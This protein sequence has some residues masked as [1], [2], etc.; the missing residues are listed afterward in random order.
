[1]S[2][3]WLHTVL[4]NTDDGGALGKTLRGSD[5]HVQ[6]PQWSRVSDSVIESVRLRAGLYKR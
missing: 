6:V 4:I 2:V 5:V 1:M 3:E